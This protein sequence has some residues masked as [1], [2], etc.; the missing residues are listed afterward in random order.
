MR[1]LFSLPPVVLAILTLGCS[2]S[3]EDKFQETMD[4]VGTRL[5]EGKAEAKKMLAAAL[6]RWEELRPEAERA[7][8]SLE[9]RF[10]R[11]VT[12]AEAMKRLPPETLERVRARIAALREKL[13][14]ANADHEQGHTDLA[15]EKADDVQRETAQ[16]EEL[17]VE[18]PD[19]R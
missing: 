11:L 14:Q 10:E 2:Q 18:R 12:D 1:I 4:E 8:A 19:P 3:T 16:V 15:V 13:A 5:E 6:E 7:L 17:L 9:E